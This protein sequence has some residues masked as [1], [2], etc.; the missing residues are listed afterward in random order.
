M[1]SAKQNINRV[2]DALFDIITTNLPRMK[3]E[4]IKKLT[5]DIR[6][7][8]LGIKPSLLV[9]VVS[10]DKNLPYLE[11][12]IT[13]YNFK[14]NF[15]SSEKHQLK[16]LKIKD[17]LFVANLSLLLRTIKKRRLYIDASSKLQT[18][19][20]ITESSLSSCHSRIRLITG[21]IED[22]LKAFLDE[23]SEKV[24]F[25]VQ[26]N[27]NWNIST[28]F[29]I[30]IDYPIVYWYEDEDAETCLTTNELLN[31]KLQ[32]ILAVKTWNIKREVYSFTVPVC[33]INEE[34]DSF[35]EAWITSCHEHAELS[36]ILLICDKNK[37]TLS[38]VIL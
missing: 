27:Y 34:V 14:A 16:I 8:C 5:F 32:T 3:K 36:D 1:L 25:E 38:T 7:V 33:L 12:I 11:S 31:I 22:Q 29:G 9:D 30:L 15:P 28:I 6:M 23:K 35:L 37:V 10:V 26:L 17:D 19:M 21:H 13:E 20:L 2:M 4:T 24:I 18:P